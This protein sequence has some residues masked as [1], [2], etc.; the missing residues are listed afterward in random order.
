MI[1]KATLVAH[2]DLVDLFILARHDPL[3]GNFSIR[4]GFA[5][6]I[7]G[8]VAAHRAL[9]ANRGG[10]FHLPG[11]RT[12]AEIRGGQRADRAD[13]GGV[14]G[15]DRV[16]SRFRIGNDLGGTA[17]LV[18]AQHRLA[19]NLVLETDAAGA[20][21]AAF[22]VQPDQ[23]AQGKMLCGMMISRRKMKRL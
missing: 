17:A 8:D 6:G 15:E 20:L 10:S 23:I 4:P 14:A 19:G 12:K 13:I 2:P 16:E 5:A 3:D 11:A 18:E 22:T 1:G 7:E 9:R 21:D